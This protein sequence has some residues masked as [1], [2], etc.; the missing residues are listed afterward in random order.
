MENSPFW[1]SKGTVKLE[2][3]HGWL[4]LVWLCGGGL[5]ISRHCIRDSTMQVVKIFHNGSCKTILILTLHQGCAT[6]GPYPAPERVTSGPRNNLKNTRNYSW[7]TEILWMNLNFIELW[8]IL[9]LFTIWNI[10]DGKNIRLW[11]IK[12]L[13]K[14]INRSFLFILNSRNFSS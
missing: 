6:L 1:W 12:R 5:C 3:K 11:A 13:V 2:G 14:F 7:M 10:S 9:Q 8:T 4:E